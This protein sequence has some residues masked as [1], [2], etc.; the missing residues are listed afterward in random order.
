MNLI[1][2]LENRIRE[3]VDL[4]LKNS[5]Q[6]QEINF[7]T[8]PDFVIEVPRDEN[9]GDFACNVAMLLARQ[10]KKSP[11][12]IANILVKHILQAN[13][14]EIEKVEI[15][16]AGF[17]NIFINDDWLYE[18]PMVVCQ[19]GKEYGRLETKNSKIQVEF[20]SANPTGNLHMGNARG[21]ALGD[22]LSN[23]LSWAGYQ[24]EK[25][26]YI[27]DAGNQIEIL[28]ASLEA[29]YL[30]QNGQ[31][32]PF[33]EDGYAGQDLV[34][35]VKQFTA[36]YGSH[37]VELESKERVKSLLDFALTEK[38]AYIKESL[39]N[40]GIKYDVWFSEKTLHESGKIDEVLNELKEA[41][42]V[43]EHEEALWFKSTQFG[44]EKDE[45]LVRANGIPTYFAADIAYH[46]NK[47]QRGFNRVI[48]IWGAD[49]HGHV[50]R[51]KGAMEALGYISDNLEIILMQ[52]VRL[53]SGGNLV[54]MSKR[55]GTTIAL[56]ELID[57]VGLDAARFTFVV[58]NPDSH[59]DFDLDLAKQKSMENP[60]YYV[61]YAHARICSVFRQAVA[62]GVDMP[63]WEDVNA[64]LLVED[65]EKRLLRK[66][67]DFPAEIEVAARNLAPHRIARYLTD[68][69]GLFHS[70]Y[71]N[72]RV[73]S[74]NTELQN[75][76][77]LLLHIT[78]TTISNALMIIGVSAPEQM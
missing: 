49:H 63:S 62:F 35:L 26:F 43:Y 48:N 36:K 75:A 23:L 60:V 1:A 29:R 33:P 37:L 58:R 12:D 10:A 24:V 5:L 61:Q 38:I 16:G 15:A 56:D 51:M 67:A 46:K 45:V 17:I 2:A 21:G 76:R 3:L 78:R 32:V 59:L 18:L 73:L 47:F 71:N 74:E 54:R 68:L 39:L 20:V 72:F 19:L 4:A 40:F 52:L 53:Y 30:Q 7:E 55:T 70:Y 41:G 22:S 25:E 42:Y 27:N 8:V 6:A 64:G 50:K 44:D 14:K 66:I 9:H 11:K 69:A 28:G 13:A 34:D 31:S 65:E 57:E 77:L